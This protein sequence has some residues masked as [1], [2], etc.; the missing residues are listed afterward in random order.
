MRMVSLRRH[1]RVDGGGYQG[2][3]ETKIREKEGE[4]GCWREGESWVRRR[5]RTVNL[6]EL[7]LCYRVEAASIRGAYV[8][9]DW[10]ESEDENREEPKAKKTKGKELQGKTG[11]R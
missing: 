5:R 6:E 7:R 3:W 11:G 8:D 10:G 9:E 4:K 2:L 1:C